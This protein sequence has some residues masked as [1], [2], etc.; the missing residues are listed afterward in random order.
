MNTLNN[1]PVAQEQMLYQIMKTEF[2]VIDTSLYLNTHPDDQIALMNHRALSQRLSLLIDQ[3]ERLYGPF[4][5]K[6]QSRYCWEFVNSPWP[7]EISYQGG[8][9]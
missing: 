1:Y 3:Y 7:W 2:A 8:M 9:K 4:T 6:G 5:P